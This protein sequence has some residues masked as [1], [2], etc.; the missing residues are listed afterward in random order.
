[1][2]A[3]LEDPLALEEEHNPTRKLVSIEYSVWLRL[4][5]HGEFGMSYSDLV[6]NILDRLEGREVNPQERSF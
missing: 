3:A 5:K 2:N 4:K 6:S 1:M